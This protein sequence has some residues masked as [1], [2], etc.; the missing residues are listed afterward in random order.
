MEKSTEKRRYRRIDCPEMKVD[1]KINDRVYTQS[2][3]NISAGGVF[4][5][6]DRPVRIGNDINMVFSD[7]LRL[8]LVQLTGN[9]IRKGDDGFGVAFRGAA[10]E[11]GRGLDAFIAGL[12]DD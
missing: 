8:C 5:K 9:V 12:E 11:G 2:I 1:C 3:H 6:S 10:G 4:V 7:Y